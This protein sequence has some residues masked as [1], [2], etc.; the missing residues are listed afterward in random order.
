MIRC[1]R[2]EKVGL[3]FPHLITALCKKVN[4]PM[5]RTERW[6]GLRMP[7]FPPLKYGQVQDSNTDEEEDL[8]QNEEEGS[9]IK[10]DTKALEPDFN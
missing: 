2:E 6:Y 3:L 1:I 10:G 9:A 4:V 8:K 7:Q 5:G